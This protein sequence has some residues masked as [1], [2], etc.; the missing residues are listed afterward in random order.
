MPQFSK[1]GALDVSSRL[2]LGVASVG[3]HHGASAL[4]P[5]IVRLRIQAKRP[6]AFKG[7]PAVLDAPPRQQQPT[8]STLTA[9]AYQ[10]R[11]QVT[12]LNP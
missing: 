5:R 7:C 3:L 8:N 2:D 6:V 11:P 10:Y 1:I 12:D 9:L 4:L